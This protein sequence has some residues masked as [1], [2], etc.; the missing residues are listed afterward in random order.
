MLWVMAGGGTG[1]HIYPAIA[2]V[3]AAR[4]KVPD[5]QVHF[6]GSARR[7]DQ[8]LFVRYGYP[9]HALPVRPFPVKLLSPQSF[10][11]VGS[12]LWGLS[13]ALRLFRRW[14]PTVVIGTGGYASLCAL[15]AGRLVN[16]K[17]VLFEANAVPGRTNKILARFADLIATG[18][19][20][21]LA[22][23]PPQKAFFSGVPIRPDFLNADRESA[24]RKLGLRDGEHLLLV[25]GGSQGAKRLNEALWDAL[26]LLLP[27]R[28]NLRIVHFC[29]TRWEATAQQICQALPA[30]WRDRYQP[31]G[32]RDDIALFL[33]AADLAVSRA[34]A[35]AIAE[36]LVAGVPAILVPYPFAIHDHQRFNALSVVKRGAAEMVLDAELTGERLAKEVLSLLNDEPRRAQMRTAAHQLA[37]PSAADEIV[38]RTLRLI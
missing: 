38:E 8:D 3:T 6:V 2:L 27:Q 34:G 14:R 10:L 35:N 25:V 18:F 24:R 15:L 29:G 5:L 12:W 22:H 31:F 11:A 28:E 23:F 7:L 21:A 26:P 16:A 36:L 19:P 32:Y 1:G 30:H 17:G 37:R 33:A 4:R 9:F 20:E 13:V